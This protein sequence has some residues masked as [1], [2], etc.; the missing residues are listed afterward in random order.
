MVE[1]PLCRVAGAVLTVSA[2]KQS[3]DSHISIHA[4]THIH[5][6]HTMNS[7]CSLL[8]QIT[9]RAYSGNISTGMGSKPGTAGNDCNYMYENCSCNVY[10]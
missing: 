4:Y 5:I 3:Y 8:L 6:I 9:S 2:Y 10:Q 1:Q 7:A